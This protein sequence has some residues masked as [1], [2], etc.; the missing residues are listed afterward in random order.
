MNNSSPTFAA[1]V[2]V[3]VNQT[4][5]KNQQQPYTP[6][7][8]TRPQVG[9]QDVITFTVITLIALAGIVTVNLLDRR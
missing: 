8:G 2:Y 3:P 1:F 5:F 4:L 9:P 7:V 6:S